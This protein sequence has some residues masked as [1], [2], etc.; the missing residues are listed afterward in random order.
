MVTSMY[1]GLDPRLH[2]AAERSV[3]AHLLYL[4][5]RGLAVRTGTDWAAA[6]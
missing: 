4:E 3:L 2:P 1:G 6:T 5:A